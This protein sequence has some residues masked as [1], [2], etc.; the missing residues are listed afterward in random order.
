MIA[1]PQEE[2][3]HLTSMQR[4]SQPQAQKMSQLT[5]Q[6]EQQTHIQDPYK[7]LVVQASTLEEMKDLKEKIR[8]D[9]SLGTPKPYR[10]R[11]LSLFR[12]VEPVIKFNERG[13]MLRADGQAIEA[14]RAEDLIQHAVRDRRRP[15]TPTGWDEFVKGLKSHNIPRAMLNRATLDELEGRPILKAKRKSY[16]LTPPPTKRRASPPLSAL[17]VIKKKKRR[18]SLRYPPTEFLKDF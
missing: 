9:L 14:S 16:P 5:Q 13:E 8:Q 15:F 4:L 17:R 7:H 6:Y 2:Y 1:I 10:N 12:S 11:A 18:P 3:I